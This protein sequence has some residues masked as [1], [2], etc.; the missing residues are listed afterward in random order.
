MVSR[1]LWNRRVSEAAVFTCSDPP[2]APELSPHPLCSA[3]LPLVSDLQLL[4]PVGGLAFG[5]SISFRNSLI[6]QIVLGAEASCLSLASPLDTVAE[7][8]LKEPTDVALDWIT[9]RSG[10]QRT[11]CVQDCGQNLIAHYSPLGL[12]TI[13]CKCAYNAHPDVQR[14]RTY[15]IRA[16][17]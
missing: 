14:A 12:P 6:P 1:R 7:H 8:S 16:P 3:L 4:P 9:R 10:S 2:L 13:A 5:I 17:S 15:L 11:V